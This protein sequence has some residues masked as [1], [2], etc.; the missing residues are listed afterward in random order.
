[1]SLKLTV[2]ELSKVTG[3]SSRTLRYYDEIDLFKSSG[4]LANG[5]RYYTIDKIEEIHF[6]NYMRHVGLSIKEIKHHLSNRNINEY[7]SILTD[8]LMKVRKEI[9]DLQKAEQRIQKRIASL[10]YI[11]QLPPIGEIVIQRLQKRRILKLVLPITKQEDWEFSLAKLE[12][13][14]D[15]PPSMIIGDLGFF[16]NMDKLTTRLPE[17]FYG[18]F[19][20]A[21]D[22]YYDKVDDLTYLDSGKWLTLYVRGDHKVAQGQYDKLLEF[23]DENK[24]VLGDFAIE[25]TVIDH[26]ISSDPNLYITE[27]QIPIVT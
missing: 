9:I 7:E 11:R 8:H 4:S 13:D 6:I 1:M 19:L 21:D 3:V 26:Y 25:R 14:H 24:L 5:Y 12:K 15:L 23:A 16:V 10:E 18:L 22:A 20:L 27:I 2:H 17:E